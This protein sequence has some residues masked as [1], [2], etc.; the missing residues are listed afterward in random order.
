M[1]HIFLE[2]DCKF[3]YSSCKSV[4]ILRTFIHEK[5]FQFGE[6]LSWT[7]IDVWLSNFKKNKSRKSAAC[8][9]NQLPRVNSLLNH[10]GL[11]RMLFST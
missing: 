7:K 4:D 11:L 2:L 8:L 5:I 1:F 10:L 9:C 3:K 6:I